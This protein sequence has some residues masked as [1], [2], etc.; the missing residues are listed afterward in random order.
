MLL[1]T[2]NHHVFMV[3]E[4]KQPANSAAATLHELVT[5]QKA[6]VIYFGASKA[7][8]LIAEFDKS[9]RSAP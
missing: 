2:A 8:S 4:L 7:V 1:I 6:V 9:A 5:C 3:A